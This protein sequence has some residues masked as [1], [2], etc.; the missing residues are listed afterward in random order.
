MTASEQVTRAWRDIAHRHGCDPAGADAVL[1]ELLR[2]Y[3]E[4][5]RHYHT[6]THIAELLQLL[7]EHGGASDKDA[8]QLVILF[9]DAM[10]D[11]ASRDN[12]E[13]SAELAAQRL[14]ALG[15]PA[16]FVAKVDRF[17]RATRHSL[18]PRRHDDPDLNLLLDLD[19]SILAAPP[20][21]YAA[22][23]A[24]IREEYRAVPQDVFVAGRRAMLEGFLA[25]KQIY[26]T[27]RL[28]AL[29]EAPARAN[30]VAELAEPS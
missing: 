30:M 9:H 1:A 27:E 2:A 19:L 25:R 20:D 4:P 12:E 11:P 16:P 6:L 14:A 18:P 13:E 15:F 10:Y 5:H 21:R 22:Y 17:I 8:V 24:A 28:R 26:L 29:W 23:V 3:S 7:E